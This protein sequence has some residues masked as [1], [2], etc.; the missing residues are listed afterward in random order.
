MSIDVV[1]EVYNLPKEALKELE[2]AVEELVKKYKNQRKPIEL[3]TK[4]DDPYWGWLAK[5]FDPANKHP[6][7]DM[8][9]VFG[10][11]V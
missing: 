8:L 10:D 11:Y 3:G 2:P 6:E 1:H 5:E 4:S 7:I 9:E